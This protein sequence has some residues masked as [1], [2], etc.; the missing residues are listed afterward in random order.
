MAE[1]AIAKEILDAFF[2]IHASLG[3]GL[4]ESSYDTVLA[5]EPG[6]RGLRAVPE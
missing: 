2:R 5:D 3:P 6:R 4:L 1:N